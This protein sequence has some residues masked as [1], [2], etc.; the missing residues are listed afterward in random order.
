MT[1]F[2][3]DPGRSPAQVVRL[4][5]FILPEAARAP[6]LARMATN[7]AFLRTLPGFQGHVVLEKRAG[8]G[9]Y[10]LVTLATWDSQVALD[11]A[12]LAVRAYYQQLGLDLASTLAGWGVQMMR[13]DYEAPA[14]LS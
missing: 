9:A 5:A 10:N 12:G 2:T 4:D 14:G 1:A 7:M 8:E 11:A 3:I 6:F 13:A